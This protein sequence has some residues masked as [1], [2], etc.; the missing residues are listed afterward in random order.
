[1]DA[2]KDVQGLSFVFVETLGLDRKQGGRVKG[3]AQ[4]LLDQLSQPQLVALLDR[5]ERLSDLRV[6]DERLKFADQA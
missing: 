3:N 2:P 1:V 5:L 4:L 6:L